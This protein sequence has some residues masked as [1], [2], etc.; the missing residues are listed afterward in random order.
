MPDTIRPE[1]NTNCIS[2]INI[3]RMMFLGSTKQ[4]YNNF[5]HKDWKKK[6][7]GNMRMKDRLIGKCFT[8]YR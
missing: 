7:Q 5:K 3:Q 6:L 2:K 1:K 8:L 4:S